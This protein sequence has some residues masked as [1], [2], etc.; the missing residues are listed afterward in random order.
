MDPIDSAKEAI[1]KAD[2]MLITAG[3]GM[4]VDSGLP[5]FRGNEGFWNAYSPLAALG[6]SFSS[7][8]SPRWFNDD[9]E[10]A[11]GFYGHR[12]TLYRHT[13]PHDGFKLLLKAARRMHGGYF[14]VT[15][16]VDGQCQKAGLS[17]SEIFSDLK[18]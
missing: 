2:A 13:T 11:W 6:L 7:I 18:L 1:A 8:A 12:L 16:N 9:P 10:L 15:S 4:G 14:V 5:D 3:A 17:F